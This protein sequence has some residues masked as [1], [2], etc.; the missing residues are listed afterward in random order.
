MVLHALGD[1]VGAKAAYERALKIDEAAF[2]PD[3]HQVAIRVSSLGIVLHDLGDFAGAKAA[4]ERAL[5]IDEVAFG[6]DHP[7]VAKAIN[8]R[9]MVLHSLDDHYRLKNKT[10]YER[11]LKI[12]KE[13]CEIWKKRKTPT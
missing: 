11:A 13:I 9:N 5:K 8:N 10:I 7:K 12:W 4:F 3:H 6:S 1:L 2:G